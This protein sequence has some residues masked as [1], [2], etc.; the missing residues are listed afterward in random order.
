[1]DTT[2]L[3]EQDEEFWH[4]PAWYRALSLTERLGS[5]SAATSDLS[6]TPGRTVDKVLSR[7]HA[8]K[9]QKPFDQEAL[10]VQR[11]ALDSLKEQEL[12]SILAEPVDS[13]KDR[14]SSVP[15]WLA[16]LRDTFADAHAV[17]KML[18]L[19]QETNAHHP[20]EACLPGLSPLFQRGLASLEEGVQA[21]RQRYEFLPFDTEMLPEVFLNNIVHDILFQISKPVTLELHIA[22]LQE[23]LHGE[24]SEE[25]FGH[26]MR[27]LSQEKLVLPLLA[28][29]PV[30]ARQLV[31]TIDQWADYACEFL[32][33]I[34]A[35]WQAIC[36]TFTPGSDPGQLMEVQAG[37]GD[38]HRRGRSVL[39]LRFGSGMQLLYKPKP[40][41]VDVH[42]Q[43]L[44]TWLNKRGAEP[45]LRPL[46]LIDRGDYGWSEFVKSS[47]CTS[48]EEVARFYERQ[49][50]YL[51]LL[52]ALDA[53]DFH[54]ENLIAAGEHPMFVDLEAL[55]HPHVHGNDPIL[56]GNL[57]AR[58]MDQSVWQ[59]GILPQRL[60][61]GKDSPG[62]DMSG[63]GGQPGQMMP[64]PLISWTETGSDQMRLARQRVEMP[65]CENQPRLGDQDVD[66]LDYR[67]AIIAGFTRMYRLLCQQRDALLT[68]QLP[69]FAHDEIR[70]VVRSTRIYGAL[71]YESFHPDLLRDALDR[72]RFFDRLWAE[73]ARRPYLA[74]I[75]P[76]ERR[77]LFRG[78]I[79]LFSTFP[80]SRTIFTSEGEPLV[81]FL[82]APSLDLVR[83]RVQRLGEQDLAKQIWIIEASLATLLM[84]R[85]DAIERPLQIKPVRRPVRRE[86]V[87]ALATAV[88]RRLEELALQNDAGAYWMGVG[89]VD[90]KSW[91]LFPTGIDL[92][93]GT[94]GIALFLAYLG[95]ITGESSYTRLAKRALASLRAQVE[96]Q[97]KYSFHP[98]V[99]AFV[100]LGSLIYLFTHV[101]VL[102]NEAHRLREAEELVARLPALICKDDHLDIIHGSAGCILSLLSLYAVHPSPRTLEVAIQCGDRLLAAAQPMPQGIAWKTL[103]DQRPLGGFS[104]G[105][106]GIA[107]SLLK[108]AA[109]SGQERFRH[110]ALGA[111]AYDRSLFV[112]DLNNWADLRVFPARQPDPKQ[113]S[114][115]PAEA[116]Q[117][118]MVAWCHGAP[119]IGLGRLGALAQLDDAQI[120]QE[121]DIAL[122]TTVQ[123]GFA[124]NHSLCHGALGNM[125]LLLT[126]ARLFNRPED[127]EALEQAT[128]LIVGS[129]EA[130]GWI[131]A[132]P[133][134]VETPGLMTGLAGIG[135]ELL[136]LAEPDKVP[137][138]LLL[139]PPC[140]HPGGS[141]QGYSCA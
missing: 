101:G 109:S 118:S 119:G 52:Y 112:P 100:G 136:R 57:A 9:A 70:V 40:L 96:E 33:H 71:W 133:L 7:L 87:I 8:W 31:I 84:G 28:K 117:D 60:W 37:M 69:R 122:N 74:R 32:A 41:A 6:S 93:D 104:H 58:A 12:L 115:A 20:L 127:H 82:D 108:L 48:H 26:F 130:N 113:A 4:A 62:V 76:A 19:L 116:R 111:L 105:T 63:L 141:E 29:Y 44:L 3:T 15:D 35:D 21:L 23:R 89:F 65:V 114:D 17:E 107:F 83:Q 95:A 14:L 30:L 56:A 138:V 42:F 49:G 90:E 80:E 73:V 86:H 39:K 72:D 79:P 5:R 27:Q 120:R 125:D 128:A 16:A 1:M 50:S 81:D 124:C 140:L 77:D 25:R 24:T 11:L 75:I 92:Y 98:N 88:G 36:T 45:R 103:R 68:E 102:W 22:R 137:S 61:S 18:P 78:D 110:T 67:G 106:A 131:T 53:T 132:V 47:P 126:A 94:A 134:G 121:I 129:L 97:E 55:F 85:E 135:Y 99:G 59:V 51:A 46:T 64:H 66:V 38:R 139:D 13:L 34:C 43:E 91:D 123:Y 10:F 54:N 2:I